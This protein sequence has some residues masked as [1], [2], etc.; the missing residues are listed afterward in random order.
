MSDKDTSDQSTFDVE[1]SQ[2]DQH[3]PSP[4]AQLVAFRE[5]RGWTIEQVASQLN[6]APRQ[7]AALEN[8]DYGALPGMPIVRG[9]IR[10]YSK[11]LKVDPAPLLAATGGE[12]VFSNQSIAPRQTLSAPFS[13]TRLP[14]MGQR[15]GLSS[16][17]VLGV[18]LLVL[19]G[20]LL[21]S[22]RKSDDFSATPEVITA[23]VESE[24]SALGS[25]TDSATPEPAETRAGQLPEAASRAEVAEEESAPTASPESVAASAKE[26][27]PQ[28]P[29]RGAAPIANSTS[30]EGSNVA[31]GNKLVL[32]VREES[33]I[34]VRRVD[35]DRI[36]IARLAAAGESASVEMNEPVSVVIGNAAGV[37]LT[38]RGNPVEL[39]ANTRA[40]VARMNLK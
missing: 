19:I 16:K 3:A 14:S 30:Q 32:E 5:Q 13:E 37:D 39:K 9:F 22:V 25:N 33:W 4:G 10:A 24:L 26:V 31:A 1:Q 11:L 2:H 15:H 40:N 23:P 6:L 20:V 21:W 34:E 36:V 29:T 8:D 28:M 27:S 38:L 35:D 12:S 17:W 18:L 7:I